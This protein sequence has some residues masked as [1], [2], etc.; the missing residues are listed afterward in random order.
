MMSACRNDG[1]RPAICK[2]ERINILESEEECER[3]F[4]QDFANGVG[5]AC[6]G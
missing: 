5:D 4:R 1:T 3:L 6:T 2:T